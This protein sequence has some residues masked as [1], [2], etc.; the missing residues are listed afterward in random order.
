[1]IDLTE[2]RKFVDAPYQAGPDQV[3]VI[4]CE[5]VLQAKDVYNEL[6][7]FFRVNYETVISNPTQAWFKY[8]RRQVYV[9]C[10]DGYKNFMSM[11]ADVM[12]FD[13]KVS[14]LSKTLFRSRLK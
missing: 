13:S 1:M 6:D 9:T 10:Q 11:R 8:G 4:V 3:L 14:D 5:D 12:L 2:V 7:Q